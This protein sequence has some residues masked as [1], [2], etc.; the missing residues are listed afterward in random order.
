[1]KDDNEPSIATNGFEESYREDTPTF[2]ITPETQHRMEHSLGA[3][4]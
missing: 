1:M 2:V 4:R 3:Y